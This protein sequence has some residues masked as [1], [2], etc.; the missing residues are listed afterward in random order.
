MQHVKPLPLVGRG[1][2]RGLHSSENQIFPARC[3]IIM[4]VSNVYSDSCIHR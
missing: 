2:G 4:N 3:W 1:L